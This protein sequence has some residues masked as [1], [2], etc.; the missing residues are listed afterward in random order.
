MLWNVTGA[1]G[2]VA[3]RNTTAPVPELQWQS[4]GRYPS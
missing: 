2:L 4:A 1:L 3:F